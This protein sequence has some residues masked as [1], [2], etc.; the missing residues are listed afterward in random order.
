MKTTQYL[1]IAFFLFVFSS[2]TWADDLSALEG[3]WRVIFSETDGKQWATDIKKG[4][5]DV[6]VVKN[7]TL[8]WLQLDPRRN[9]TI[10]LDQKAKTIDFTYVAGERKGKVL[11][12][13]YFVSGDVCTLCFGAINGNR[14]DSFSAKDEGRTLRFCRRR[15]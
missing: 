3:E 6:F 9:G 12:G 4:D 13:I 5:F 8:T 2:T 10:V 15:P 1:W 7:D 14:P 11:R